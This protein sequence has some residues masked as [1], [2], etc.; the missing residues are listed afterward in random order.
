VAAAAR[1][2]MSDGQSNLQFQHALSPHF[3]G[4]FVLINVHKHDIGYLAI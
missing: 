3:M 2:S 1:P 4:E